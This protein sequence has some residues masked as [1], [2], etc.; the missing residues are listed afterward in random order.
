[1]TNSSA[2]LSSIDPDEVE[3]FSRIADEWWDA[4]GKFKPLHEINP[5]RIQYIRDQL[6]AH[7]GGDADS[8]K[9]LKDLSLLDIGCGG[10]LISEPMARLGANVSGVDAS[11][12]NIKTAS[13]HAQSSGLEIEY[14]AS[15]AESLV[16]EG[17]Q[18]DVVLALE[19]IEHVV[20]PQAFIDSCASLVKPGGVLIMTTI[21]RTVKSYAF[22]IVGAE[23]VMRLLPRGT[24]QWQKFVKPSE[25]REGMMRNG[26][27][28]KDSSGM[29]LDPLRWQWRISDTD[30][31]VNYLICS[32]K[33][34]EG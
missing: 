6:V 31:D 23:Y 30:L 20:D 29:V 13:V 7:F 34:E 18:F 10:G 14:L 32:S 1:M 8:I 19:I 11:E 2:K 4:K 5:V 9:P 27:N 12:K 28:I 21:N 22:A 3:Q 16:E 33:S 17:R 26:L 15:T 24:H 25:M